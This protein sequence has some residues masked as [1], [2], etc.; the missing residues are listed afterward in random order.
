[1]REKVSEADSKYK[2]GVRAIV[3]EKDSGGIEV[4]SQNQA[5]KLMHIL[6]AKR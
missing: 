5:E 2:Q 1:M 3:A 6:P 4:E